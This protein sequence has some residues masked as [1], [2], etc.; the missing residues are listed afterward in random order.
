MVLDKDNKWVKVKHVF[1]NSE[2]NTPLMMHISY[3]DDEKVYTLC[4][5]EDHPLWTGKSFT[6]ARNLTIEDNIYR[7]D[8][9]KLEI[10]MIKWHFDRAESY[11]IGTETGSFIGSDIIMHNCRTMIGSDINF[12]EDYYNHL[13]ELSLDGKDI[14]HLVL[15]RAQK[16]GRG[17]IAPVTII[18]PTIAMLAEGEVGNKNIHNF[19]SILDNKISEARDILIERFNWIC[20]QSMESAKFMYENHMMAGYVPEEGIISAIKHGTL[21]IGQLGLAECLQILIDCDHTESGGMELAKGIESLFKSRCDEFKEKYKLNFGNYFTPAEN[22]CRTALVKFREKYGVI[23]KISDREYF[24]NSTHVPVWKKMS[25]F[26]K[27]DIESQLSGY[28]NAGCITYVELDGSTIKN[29]DAV[30]EIIDYAMKKDI[31]YMAINVPSDVCLD[32]GYQGEFNDKCPECG[33]SNTQQLRRVTGYLTGSYKAA[34]NAGK[35][36]EVEQRERHV[37]RFTTLEGDDLP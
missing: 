35:V 5:T 28:S 16:D 25:P 9:K 20:S 2:M 29:I 4:C 26:D 10:K 7:G 22:L 34:F 1:R 30:E 21:A 14:K 33:S 23:P 8:G 37:N 17:N 31:P 6:E 12:D 13:I 3:I 24:T 36:A 32:C 15:S 11:D 27:I 19:L 18:L